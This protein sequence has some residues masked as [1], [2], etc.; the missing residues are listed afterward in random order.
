M[1]KEK[2]C[3]SEDNYMKKNFTL[4]AATI[5]LT[6]F[7]SCA[8]HRLAEKK[9]ETEM[10]EV[11]VEKSVSETAKEF[12]MK[13]DKLSDAQK[14]KLL[15]LQSKTHAKSQSLREEIEKTKMVMIQTV[16]EP[17]MNRHEYAILKKKIK[18]LENKRMENGFTAIT[19]ARSIIEPQ[20]NAEDRIYF[21]HFMRTHL[22][23]F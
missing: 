15:E 12:I 22:Q 21:N 8:Q 4:L 13:S 10:K 6:T 7:S 20:K 16:L 3:N 14:S 9:I 2:I 23:E 5:L 11:P 1:T 18:T 17:K 19:E